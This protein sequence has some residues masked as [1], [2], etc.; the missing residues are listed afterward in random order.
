MNDTQLSLKSRCAVYLL[1]T[2]LVGL[3]GF[4]GYQQIFSTFAEYD[5]EGYVMISL[6]SFLDGHPLYD[7]TFSQY[8]PA[9]YFIEG[10]IHR[11][12]N[13][14]ITHNI[15]RLKTIVGWLVVALASAFFVNRL[16]SQDGP[17]HKT[18]ASILTFCLVFLHL[19]R[20]CLEPG[21]PQELCA[22]GVVGCLLLSTFVADAG[23]VRRKIVCGML[24]AICSIVLLTKL[25]VG[26]FLTAAVG[27][28]LVLLQPDSRFKKY[29]VGCVYAALAMLPLLL[30]RHHLLEVEAGLLALSTALAGVAVVFVCKSRNYS[31]S[32]I[33]FPELTSY[34][35]VGMLAVATVLVGTLL[36]GTSVQGLAYGLV[37]QHSGFQQYFFHPPPVT[38]LL[39]G[40]GLLLTVYAS[41]SDKNLFN[42]AALVLLGCIGAYLNETWRP[43]VHGLTLRGRADLL[44][45]V[46][47]GFLVLLMINS[48]S[49]NEFAPRLCLALI[50]LLQPLASYPTPGTQTAVG[51]FCFIIVCVL[52]LNDALRALPA[53]ELVGSFQSRLSVGLWRRPSACLLL[54]LSSSPTIV[55][56]LSHLPCRVPID[57]ALSRIS[58]RINSG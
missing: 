46:G 47:P 39:V 22:I 1:W 27:S 14:P 18:L 20:L 57:F 21:H 44:M 42:V 24:G 26:V 34:S 37:G 12:A 36:A 54:A 19:D 51:S 4:V 45:S 13:L 15:V 55:P 2:A 40:V 10:A 38:L 17:I 49:N 32:M 25:N 52:L 8:G 16:A 58:S 43:L 7:E 31:G 6:R 33:G 48:K 29:M 3:A 30:Y 9:F 50:S 53:A 11:L 41:R 35:V 56:V 5:D 28:T 23:N